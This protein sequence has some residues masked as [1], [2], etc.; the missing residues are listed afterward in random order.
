MGIRAHQRVRKRYRVGAVPLGLHDGSQVLEVDLVNDAGGRWNHSEIGERLLAPAQEFV[1]F[2]VAFELTRGV[3][4]IGR[5]R[6]EAVHLHGVID[7]QID[8]RNRIDALGVAAQPVHGGTQRREVGDCR[9]SRVILQKHPRRYEGKLTRARLRC[10]PSHQ[11][12]DVICSGTEPVA[13]PQNGFE[14]HLERVRQARYGADSFLF[15]SV[16]A[17]HRRGSASGFERGASAER[18]LLGCG[19]E[20]NLDGVTNGS[21][22]FG[23]YFL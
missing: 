3:E 12:A 8:L 18:V 23:T 6:A 14:D 7:H 19:H 16:E 5:Q 21:G 11:V 22:V 17:V 20:M 1:S 15:Q 10:L 4:I 9:Q 13:A 2:P